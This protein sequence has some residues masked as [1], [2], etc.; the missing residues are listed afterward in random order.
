[1]ELPVVEPAVTFH[2]SLN[3]TDLNRA[4]EFYRTF[5]GRPPAKSHD[6]YAKFELSD[7]SVVFSLVPHAP[8]PGCSLSHIGLRMPDEAAVRAYAERLEMAG[9]CTQAQDGTTCGY[10]KQNKVWVKDPDGN[11]WEVYHIEE[12]VDPA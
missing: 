5:F 4:V 7:P 10:A 8:G 9:V 1:M 2:L 3:V 11:F 6:D 12:D